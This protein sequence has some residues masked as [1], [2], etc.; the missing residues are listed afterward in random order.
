MYSDDNID[1]CSNDQ[2]KPYSQMFI[3]DLYRTDHFVAGDKPY[4][5]NVYFGFGT[6]H[7]FTRK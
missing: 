5:Q 2:Y 6:Y 4:C 3:V 7:T 1:L